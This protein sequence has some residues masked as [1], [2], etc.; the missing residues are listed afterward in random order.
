MLLSV[1]VLF[2][3]LF[4]H[5]NMELLSKHIYHEKCNIHAIYKK[6]NNMIYLMDMETH[7]EMIYEK[8]HITIDYGEF[9][10]AFA[11]ID[12]DALQD[13][14]QSYLDLFKKQFELATT[15]GY[16]DSK[17]TSSIKKYEEYG[18]YPN[19]VN[20]DVIKIINDTLYKPLFEFLD[21]SYLNPKQL[22]PITSLILME[23]ENNIKSDTFDWQNQNTYIPSILLY[24]EL[25]EHLENILLRKSTYFSIEIQ[26]SLFHKIISSIINIDKNGTARTVF[27]IED[28]LAFLMIDLQKYLSGTRTVLT[29]QKCGR[30]FYPKSKKNKTYCRLKHKDTSLTCNEIVHRESKDEFAQESKRARGIQQRFMDNAIAHK[31]NPKFQYDY[32]LLEVTYTLWKEQLTEQM[33]NFRSINDSKGFKKWINDTRFTVKHLEKLGIRKRKT[34]PKTKNK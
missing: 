1:L 27:L 29:C 26:R 2:T 10:L 32:D 34:T 13:I 18:I 28:T 3:F 19:A 6:E 24:K 8:Q 5:A 15:L 16:L 17:H 20:L 33:N 21:N 11:N 4:Y 25:K 31:N 9:S 7:F 22:K 12:F 30:L 23:L 14:I